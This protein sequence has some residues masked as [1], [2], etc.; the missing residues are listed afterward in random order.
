MMAGEWDDA[1][2]AEHRAV[3]KLFDEIQATEEGH[4]TRRSL[5]LTQIAHALAKHALEEE[6]A[7]YTTLRVHGQVADADRLNGDHGYV[8]QYLFEL[9]QMGPSTRCSSP[10]SAIS[11]RCS[12]SICATR[13]RR[14]SPNCA[15]C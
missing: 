14:S 7:V 1:L 10:R 6:N 11:G 4:G 3:L 12:R 5:L 9:G 13:R 8:K 15:A 2:A